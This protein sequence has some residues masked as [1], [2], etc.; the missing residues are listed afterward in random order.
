MD[1]AKIHSRYLTSVQVVGADGDG[2]GDGQPEPATIGQQGDRT[3]LV[4]R[5]GGWGGRAAPTA[6]GGLWRRQPHPSSLHPEGAVVVADRDQPAF[7]AWEPGRLT[8]ASALGGL[9][10]GVRIPAQH[11]PGPD[12]RQLPGGSWCGQLAA[13]RLI[14][15]DR[16]RSLLDP[17]PVAVQQ[18]GPKITGR[19]STLETDLWTSPSRGSPPTPTAPTG[20]RPRWRPAAPGRSTG[21][22]VD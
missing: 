22:Q 21:S 14:A 18:P 20:G 19:A 3:D 16:Q 9:E 8:I 13:Q 11:R 5:I 10:P 17:L 12:R 1:D 7:A 4:G 15:D 2:G 6:P